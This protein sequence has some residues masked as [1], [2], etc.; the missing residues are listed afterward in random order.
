MFTNLKTIGAKGSLYNMLAHKPYL[1]DYFTFNTKGFNTLKSKFNNN[2]YW[3]IK[4]NKSMKQQGIIISNHFNKIKTHI[5]NSIFNDWVAQRYI[6]NPLLYNG[7]KLHLRVYVLIVKRQ[8]KFESYLYKKGYIYVANSNYKFSHFYKNS[9]HITSS[10]N[11]QEFPTQFNNYYGK[12]KFQ[13]VVYPQLKNIVY[14]TIVNIYKDTKWPNRF[15]DD[16]VCY[17]QLGYDIIL[18]ENF[19]AYIM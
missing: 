4:P 2:T 10:C 15:I 5:T 1:P 16:Y 7:K 8:Y 6:H 17:K 12:N 11:Y 3:L 14:D 18:D 13:K 19:N 9:I